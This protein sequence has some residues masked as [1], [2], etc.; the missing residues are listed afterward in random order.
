MCAHELHHHERLQPLHYINSPE[1][2]TKSLFQTLCIK[3]IGLFM[4]TSPFSIHVHTCSSRPFPAA[5]FP[6]KCWMF[7]MGTKYVI[8]CKDLH[9]SAS[10]GEENGV[11]TIRSVTFD[12]CTT[13]FMQDRSPW[14]LYSHNVLP[15]LP[16][17][18]MPVSGRT[19]RARKTWS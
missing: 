10:F 16:V 14:N 12:T 9:T 6:W 19:H 11:S 3:S 8:K 18:T 13:S 15:L 7:W 2:R 1:S 5:C 17:Q 4:D